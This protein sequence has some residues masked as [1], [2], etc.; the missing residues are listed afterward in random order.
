MHSNH[1]NLVQ[2][3][4]DL[5]SNQVMR[6]RLLVMEYGT[7]R[8]NRSDLTNTVVDAIRRL[9]INPTYKVSE[10][11]LQGLDAKDCINGEHLQ[12]SRMLR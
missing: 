10:E 6:W 12:L 8:V 11:I 2:D 9:D 7:K 3:V 4:V 1:K 5:D